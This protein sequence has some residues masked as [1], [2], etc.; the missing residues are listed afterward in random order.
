MK[1]FL[2]STDF[3]P[4]PILGYEEKKINYHIFIFLKA[5]SGFWN[6]TQKHSLRVLNKLFV[7]IE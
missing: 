4:D 7:L 2:L 6:I 3:V 5:L 1:A